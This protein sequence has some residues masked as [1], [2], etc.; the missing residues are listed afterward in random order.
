MNRKK[1]IAIALCAVLIFAFMK[2]QSGSG[3]RAEAEPSQ[4]ELPA[5]ITM[6]A[7][8]IWP[9]NEYTAGVPVPPGTVGW[10]MLDSQNESCSIQVQSVPQAQFDDYYQQLQDTGYQEIERTEE[11]NEISIGTLL[12][13]G[14]RSISLA[15]SE[16]TLMICLMNRGIN[17]GSRGF[18]QSGNLE[19]VYVN[20]YATYDDENGIQVVT[21]LYVLD[22][23]DPKP[24]F[25]LVSGRVTLILGDSGTVHYLGTECTGREAVALAV[26]TGVTGASGATGAVIIAGTAWAENAAG[27]GGSFTVSFDITIP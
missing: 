23:A 2:N 6:L 15:Y 27:G 12:S 22:S 7:E 19:N 20:G 1:W 21:E 18:L 3:A 13:D 24:A 4:T 10:A 14:S 9:E 5:F 8:G 11:K 25:E 17:G 16:Q 26:N